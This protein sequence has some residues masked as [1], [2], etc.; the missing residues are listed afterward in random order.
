MQKIT[1]REIQ[2]NLASVL[3]LVTSGQEVMIYHRK[4]PVARLL[5]TDYREG[6]DWGDHEREIMAIFRGR[7][8]QRQNPAGIISETRHEF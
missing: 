8:L 2:H 5:S 6:A 7:T 4:T 1:I 3:K